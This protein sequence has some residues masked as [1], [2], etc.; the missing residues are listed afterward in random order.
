MGSH[1]SHVY[2]DLLFQ[3][4]EGFAK[5][6]HTLFCLELLTSEE[7]IRLDAAVGGSLIERAG[8]VVVLDSAE[9]EPGE[10]ARKTAKQPRGPLAV[11]EIWSAIGGWTDCPNHDVWEKARALTKAAWEDFKPLA[12]RA[13]A[14]LPSEI[15]I[16]LPYEPAHPESWWYNLLFWFNSLLENEDLNELFKASNDRRLLAATPFEDSAMLIEACLLDSA[17]PTPPFVVRFDALGVVYER[18]TAIT[19]QPAVGDVRGRQHGGHKPWKPTQAVK[20][21]VELMRQGLTNDAI[22]NRADVKC[23]K[24]AAN[25]RQ[26]RKKAKAEGL[27]ENGVKET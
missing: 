17:S 19:T 3:F 5:H 25:L 12:I 4:R 27:L 10:T 24:S 2:Q 15:R 9:S 8:S 22:S 20:H 7:R 18:D 16:S 1:D 21:V 6:S 14:H 13:G 26:I 11:F 23:S